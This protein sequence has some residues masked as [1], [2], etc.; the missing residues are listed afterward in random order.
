MPTILTVMAHP[1]DAEILCGGTLALLADRG[2][3]VHIATAS[4]G[5]CGSPDLEPEKIA[6]LRRGEG[7]AAA[8]LI[9]GSFHCL[10]RR[11][12]RICYD[13]DGIRRVTTLLRRVRPDVVITHSPADYMLDHEETS[14]L[15]RAAC[16]NAPIPNAPTMHSRVPPAEL[17]PHLYY[18]DPIEGVDP[19]GRPVE[20]W[21]VVDISTTIA[22]KLDMLS[23]HASQ[24]EWLR[25]HHGMDEYLEATRRWSTARGTL[26]GVAHGEGF[27]QHLGHA[28]PRTEIF[29][30]TLGELVRSSTTKK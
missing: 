15:A 18:A 23:R 11:D 7:A 2:W 24:R 25:A 8:A 13:E 5:D 26:V 19:L 28:Y 3:D 1:D 6:D 29:G 14:R 17:I 21:I 10:E 30:E 9:N 20:P 27:R 16:F 12:L 22:T 4:P